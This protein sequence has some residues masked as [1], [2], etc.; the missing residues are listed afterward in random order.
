MNDFVKNTFKLMCMGALAA[1]NE[2][3]EK[4]FKILAGRPLSS[5]TEKDLQNYKKNAK[6]WEILIN[7]RNEE[8]PLKAD[9]TVDMTNYKRIDVEKHINNTID[10]ML[11]FAVLIQLNKD[12]GGAAFSPLEMLVEHNPEECY[13]YSNKKPQLY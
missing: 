12:L 10:D 11:Q 9:G 5:V 8:L 6:L 1:F 2:E 4:V 7:L 3:Q 13:L